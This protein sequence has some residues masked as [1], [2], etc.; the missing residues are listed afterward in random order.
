MALN[1]SSFK[2]SLKSALID[3]ANKNNKDNVTVD[4][5]MTNLANAIA[6]QVDAYIKTAE[7]TVTALTGEVSVQGSAT[8]QANVAP[9]TLTGNDATH[10]GGLS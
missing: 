2:S 9:I 8:A 3:A 1:L 5:A 10:S 7:V 6:G 4:T